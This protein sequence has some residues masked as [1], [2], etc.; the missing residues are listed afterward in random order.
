[1]KVVYCSLVH[2]YFVHTS[3]TH[4]LAIG[5]LRIAMQGQRLRV[6]CGNEL[7][8]RFGQRCRLSKVRLSTLPRCHVL[9]QD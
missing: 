8:V 3:M 4:S 2:I 7:L 6:D 5:E 9:E 1:M